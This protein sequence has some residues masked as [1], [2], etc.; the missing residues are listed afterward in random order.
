MPTYYFRISGTDPFFT[1]DGVELSNDA[2]AWEEARS[3]L[4][5]AEESLQAG[6]DWTLEVLRDQCPLFRIWLHSEKAGDTLPEGD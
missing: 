5:D 3:L 4:R 1:A 2:V 6:E